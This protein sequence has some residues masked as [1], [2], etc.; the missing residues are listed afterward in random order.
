MKLSYLWPKVTEV[1][2]KILLEKTDLLFRYKRNLNR[3][4]SQ[5]MKLQ[6][7][8]IILLFMLVT[9]TTESNIV[10]ISIT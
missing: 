9:I 2:K 7:P 5:G 3:H 6:T 1:L 8:R 10:H 4:R